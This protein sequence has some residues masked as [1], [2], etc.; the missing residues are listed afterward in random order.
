MP[1]ATVILARAIRDP[2][3]LANAPPPSSVGPAAPFICG[4]A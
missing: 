4:S 2:E 3:D 1:I